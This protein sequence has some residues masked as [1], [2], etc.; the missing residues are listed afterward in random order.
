MLLIDGLPDLQMLY[1]LLS[2]EGVGPSQCYYWRLQTTTERFHTRKETQTTRSGQVISAT[3]IN[4]VY[5]II[6]NNNAMIIT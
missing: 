1:W 6:D 3:N 2:G 5:S 4:S